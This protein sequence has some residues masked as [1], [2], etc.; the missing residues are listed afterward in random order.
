MQRPQPALSEW[1]ESVGLGDLRDVLLQHEHPDESAPKVHLATGFNTALAQ[2]RG[3]L[4]VTNVPETVTINNHKR[5]R[6]EKKVDWTTMR[7]W[8]TQNEKYTEQSALEDAFRTWL[9]TPKRARKAP[10]IMIAK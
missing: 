1:L 9:E 8:I 7:L 10:D 4:P 2:A 6:D 5:M 3:A